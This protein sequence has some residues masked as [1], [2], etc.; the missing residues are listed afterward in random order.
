MYLL[1]IRHCLLLLPLFVFF[2]LGPRFVLQYFVRFAIVLLGERESF[3]LVV[4]WVLC[5]HSLTLSRD[6]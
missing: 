2:V 6:W 5:R 3:L 1:L 4:L